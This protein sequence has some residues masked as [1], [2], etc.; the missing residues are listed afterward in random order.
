MMWCN[1]LLP[2]AFAAWRS[3]ASRA[4]DLASSQLM[5]TR[6]RELTAKHQLIQ[7]W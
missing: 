5:L 3:H 1:K 4:Q 2:G 7:A 6:R